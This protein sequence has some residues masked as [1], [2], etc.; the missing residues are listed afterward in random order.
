MGL[1]DDIRVFTLDSWPQDSP[2]VISRWLA[3]EHNLCQTLVS[4]LS[5]KNYTSLPS[6]VWF[7]S[8]ARLATK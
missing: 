6:G 3:C 2:P 1:S 5:E 8:M 7:T 4:A